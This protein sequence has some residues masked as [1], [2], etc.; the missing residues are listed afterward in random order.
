M[1]PHVIPNVLGIKKSNRDTGQQKQTETKES[2]HMKYSARIC[3]QDLASA[4]CRSP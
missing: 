1:K 2:N 4:G 3:S